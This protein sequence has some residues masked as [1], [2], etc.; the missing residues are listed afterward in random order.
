MRSG[1]R[2]SLECVATVF[3]ICAMTFAIVGST[4]AGLDD[5]L[6]LIDGTG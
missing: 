5:E 4:H 3:M 6:T 1:V 2:R